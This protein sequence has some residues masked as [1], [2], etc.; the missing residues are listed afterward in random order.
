M[1]KEFN[2]PMLK[3]SRF[4]DENIVTNSAIIMEQI[5]SITGQ[6]N[7]GGQVTNI[8]DIIEFKDWA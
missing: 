7:S 1:K 6:M 3:I 4:S 2:M 8:A 5:Q